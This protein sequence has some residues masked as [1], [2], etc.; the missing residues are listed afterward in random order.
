[1]RQFDDYV[2]P[3]GK[4][5]ASRISRSNEL[6]LYLIVTV[7]LLVPCFWQPHMLAGDLP[8]HV[9]NAWLASQVKQG[10]VAGLTVATRYTNVLTDVVLEALLNASGRVW[11]ERVTVG[12]SVEIFFWGAFFFVAKVTGRNCWVIAPSLGILA[13]GLVFQMGF[14]NFY[15]ATGLSLWILGLL[16][17]PGARWRWLV[18]PLAI[19]ALLAHAMP[20]AWAA[21]ALV[22]VYILRKVGKPQRILLLVGGF[23]FLVLAQTI[24][25]SMFRSEWS[26][27]NLV[28]VEGILGLSG[29]EQLWLWGNKYLIAVFGILVVWFV[30]FLDRLDRTGLLSEPIAHLWLLTICGFLLLPVG[31]QFP[32]YNHALLFIPQ[33]MSL[34]VA[35]TFCA[36]IAGGQHGRSLTRVSCLVAAAFFTA[37]YFDA[38]AMNRVETEI[39]GV[40]SSVPQGARVTLSLED[41]S[42]TR[43]NGILHLADALCIERCWVY[44]NFEAATRAFQVEALGPNAVVIDNME[45]VQAIENGTYVVK[46]EEAPVYSLCAGDGPAAPFLFRIRKA[47]DTVC[48]VTLPVT[49]SF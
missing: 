40:L 8:S 46:P 41:E 6:L 16:W 32:Q 30:L 36:L 23:C 39:A 26:L 48:K 43:L 5:L 19:L 4:P 38:Q 31:I 14:L 22:Y 29:A 28:G 13:Y 15:V 9:Y 18:L 11:A 34:F 42:S 33:R 21:G 20:V 25:L 12:A 47:G 1:V 2:T 17:D 7:A 45:S 35:L 49:S 37:L 3:P 27:A 10:H 24:L 44:G